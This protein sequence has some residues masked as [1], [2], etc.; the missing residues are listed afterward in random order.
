MFFFECLLT[1]V[2][3]LVWAVFYVSHRVLVDP[4]YL[5]VPVIT[6][7]FWTRVVAILLLFSAIVVQ[8]ELREF[9]RPGRLLRFALLIGAVA[10]CINLSGFYALKYTD[11]S[12]GSI[13]LK[14]D[15]LFTLI[16]SRFL[17]SEKMY[18]ADWMGT[19]LMVIGTVVLL[20]SKI[21]HMAPSLIGDSLFLLIAV[22]LTINAFIIKTKLADMSNR[23][24]ATYNSSVT[25]MGFAVL[26][27][28]NGQCRS[29][30]QVFQD[31]T[32]TGMV[33][34]G[35][36]SV[37]ALF[38]LYYRALER[39]PFWLV[40]VLLLFT[41][42]WSVVIECSFLGK[43]LLLNEIAGIIVILS[44]AA[45]IVLSHDRRARALAAQNGSQEESHDH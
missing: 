39:L 24:T 6:A 25:L 16:A 21:W 37:A 36:G 38:L 2:L 7:G 29:S 40:R 9:I 11:A 43:K 10:F 23:V 8:K 12:S 41:P 20:W 14:T 30:L 34:L 4:N 42:V 32:M 3:S 26:L 45:L 27:V 18:R 19:A 17:L 44:G 35:G 15:I 13:I 5:H 31:V 1:V 33:L 22:L 28:L